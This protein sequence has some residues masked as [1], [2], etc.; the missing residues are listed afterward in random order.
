M[1]EEEAHTE[2]IEAWL[3]LRGE[4]LK[5]WVTR[6]FDQPFHWLAGTM[7]MLIGICMV[8]LVIFGH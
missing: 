8:I 2:K 6:S 3:H 7:L 5:A 4:W 1:N